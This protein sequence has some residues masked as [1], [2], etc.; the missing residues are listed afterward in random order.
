[1]ETRMVDV[2]VKLK[3]T[4]LDAVEKFQRKTEEDTGAKFSRSDVIRM[5]LFQ[6]LKLGTNGDGEE[7]A[8]AEEVPPSP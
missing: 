6:F 7:A 8:P 2:T 4:I 1:M 5:A 3:E